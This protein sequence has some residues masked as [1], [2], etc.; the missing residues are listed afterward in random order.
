[1]PLTKLFYLAHS[2][3]LTSYTLV[4]TYRSKSPQQANSIHD[5]EHQRVTE[6]Q[7]LERIV[8]EQLRTIQTLIGE[9]RGLI[10]ISNKLRSETM[11]LKQSSTLSTSKPYCESMPS[12]NVC[13]HDDIDCPDSDIEGFAKTLWTNVIKHTEPSMKVG[14]EFE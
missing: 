1:M 12:P 8:S 5:N 13:D 14:Y 3:L 4:F 6:I 2:Q 11:K 10:D 9:K 7:Q